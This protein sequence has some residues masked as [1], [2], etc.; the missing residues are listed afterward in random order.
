MTRTLT[1]LLPTLGLLALA[2][3]V[4]VPAAAQTNSAEEAEPASG[5]FSEEITVTARKREENLQEVP[6]SVVAPSEEVL[7]SRG[8][9]DLEEIAANVAGFTVQNL[10][11][12]QS[13]VAMRGVAAGQIV[14]DQPGVKE[15][16][17]IYLDESV[18]SLSLFTPDIDLF[19]MSRVEVLRGPQGTLFGSGSLAGTVR[20]ITNQPE[21]G[22][23]D[24]F[25]E[26]SISSVGDGGMGESA[27]VAV[28]VPVGDTTAM[29]ITAYHTSFGGFMDA[30]QPDLSVN[31]DVNSGERTGARWALRLEPSEN[32][33]VTPR[34]LYQ[35]VEM[36]GW[37]RI[38]DF[39]ILANPY[40]TSRPA[41]DLG[42]RQLFTQFEEPYTD[43]FLLAD[44]KVVVDLPDG[45]YFTSI[46]SATDRDVLVVRDSTALYA[47]VAGATIGLPE[48]VYTL[49]APLIDATTASGLT[50]E[51]RLASG[52]EYTHWVLGL[53]YGT[54]ERDYGQSLPVTGFQAMTGIPT[55][56]AFGA[57]V[58][59]LFYSDLN[60]EF[61]QTAAFFEI[62]WTAGERLDLT[63]GARWY[64]YEETRSQ[65]F[66][67]LFADPGPTEGETSA[68]GVAPRFIASFEATEN[69]QLNAQVSKG[70]RL[71]GIN[72]PLNVP[73]CTPEDLATFS[74]RDSWEDE[75]LWNVEIGSKSTIM[76]GRGTFNVAAFTMDISNLQTTVTAG[77][78]SSR[79]VFNVP[80]ARS[81]GLELELTAQPS[82][83]FD[84]AISASY[85]DS[86]L[87]STLTSTAADGT[88]SVVSGIEKG[89]RLPT[90]PRF[91]AAVAATWRWEAGDWAGYLSS[92]F[93]HVGS[94]FTQIGDHA[95]GF[96]TVDLLALSATNPVGGPLAQ[97]T[98]RFDPE[99]PAY[100]L[101]N[102]RLGFLNE[103]WDIA[104]FVNN[105]LDE[106][107]LLALDQERGTRA[108]VGYL[109]N[110][111]RTIGVSS[112]ITF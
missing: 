66:D 111:P 12:G 20:Y 47:S 28:N 73:V 11:P 14:R 70:F 23:S 9:G 90:V 43:E 95:P 44:L 92:A 24:G 98:F 21:L 93:Q 38:D 69:T 68:D 89:N 82:A 39:N 13:Q 53:F 109:T 25:G 71:G 94:R 51:L 57:A 105:A 46:T 42:E 17:G 33:T 97:T 40:T 36:D 58:D 50:Q 26:L 60:Y 85:A 81:T 59:E 91:Q 79:L 72:D 107:A 84:F 62:T 32:V 55:A 74:G 112:R 16:V 35:E 101:L 65:V 19:D 102:L 88:T 63:A 18:I 1:Q 3:T 56:G 75:E 54:S 10:G 86:E 104:L 64:D 52:D 22:V 96:G 41:V 61:D 4:P 15:Q 110:Q 7:R 100:D 78:C 83:V 80:N 77:S 30:V 5:S 99:M 106:R 2:G 34:L 108:R 49:D 27:K 8:A 67:G 37:N 76:G 6:F 87:G 31:K 103:R 29:R 48:A 45:Y